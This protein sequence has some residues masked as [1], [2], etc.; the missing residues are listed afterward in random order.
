[1]SISIII[2]ILIFVPLQ[3]ACGIKKC[4]SCG[5]KVYRMNVKNDNVKCASCVFGHVVPHDDSDAL[6]RWQMNKRRKK[7]VAAGTHQ[8]MQCSSN[9]EHVDVINK[10][11]GN[12][13]RCNH[14]ANAHKFD[15]YMYPMK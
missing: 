12:K 10:Q 1:M 11:A 14:C 15:N 9:E 5:K 4:G 3:I 8:W 7:K 13:V 2:C 6:W